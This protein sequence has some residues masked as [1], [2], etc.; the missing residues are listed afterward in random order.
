M[1]EV[2]AVILLDQVGRRLIPREV[3]Q[4]EHLHTVL[5]HPH[6]VRVVEE[7]LAVQKEVQAVPAVQKGR[8]NSYATL[9][10]ISINN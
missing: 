10:S 4:A 5:L 9:K 6:L 3:K 2:R 1:I 8:D 7:A